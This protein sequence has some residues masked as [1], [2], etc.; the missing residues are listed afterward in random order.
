MGAA[1]PGVP[2]DGGPGTGPVEQAIA[3]M[4]RK[5]AQVNG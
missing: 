3:V 4:A 1:G 2:V 5:R